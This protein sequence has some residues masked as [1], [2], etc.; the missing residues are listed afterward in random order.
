MSGLSVL[1][2]GW[3]ASAYSSPKHTEFLIS[4]LIAAQMCV[5]RNQAP[6]LSQKSSCGTHVTGRNY[7]SIT[8]S[9]SSLNTVTALQRPSSGP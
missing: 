4:R 8:E 9:C 2:T 6:I 5:L 7:A 3:N 1:F